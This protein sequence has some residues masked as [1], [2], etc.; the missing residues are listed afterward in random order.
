M[1]LPDGPVFLIQQAYQGRTDL[2][3]VGKKRVEAGHTAPG[4]FMDFRALYLE[5]IRRDV[6]AQKPLAPLLVGGAQHDTEERTRPLAPWVRRKPPEDRTAWDKMVRECLEEQRT[7]LSPNALVIP[8]V[9][10]SPAGYP[11]GFERQID[12]IRRAW[13]K[14]PAGDPDWFAHF[15]LHDDWLKD[16]SLRRF[17]LNL[18]TDLPDSIGIAMHPLFARR[19][20]STH[21]PTLRGLRTLVSVLADDERRVL[22]VKSGGLGWLSIA[23]GAWGFT[24]GRSQ[25]TW[26]DSREQFGSQ[27][28]KPKPPP[29]ERYFEPQLLHH[30]L[31]PDHVRLSK[32]STHVLCPCP[33]CKTLKTQGW[34]K[35]LAAQHDLF[36]L[37]ELT[38]RVAGMDRPTRR[39]AVRV[40]V[41]EAQNRWAEWKSTT[42]LSPQTEPRHLATWRGLV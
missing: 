18:L 10:L 31:Y 13:K 6:K 39:E 15:C 24:A 1:S 33:F 5:G 4:L 30:V 17:L 12:A 29:L 16:S 35:G 22:L 28:G 25:G 32:L 20:R 38:R 23:W 27:K 19:E 3:E 41:E 37:S 21:E 40:I 14:R 34:S 7:N 26:V 9:E 2:P 36:A 8:G 42:G 11:G